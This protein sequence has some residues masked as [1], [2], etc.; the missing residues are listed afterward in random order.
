VCVVIV[1]LLTDCLSVAHLVIHET[2]S[3]TRYE[4]IQPL[5]METT[6]SMLSTV[7]MVVQRCDGPHRLRDNDDDDDVNRL[8]FF[9]HYIYWTVLCSASLAHWHFS[10]ICQYCRDSIP[11]HAITESHGRKH[12]V[13][14]RFTKKTKYL[15]TIATGM[16]NMWPERL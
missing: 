6:G 15:L 9:Q 8:H 4:M 11:C 12:S 16:P 2:S 1:C 10:R 14:K 13:K 7:D 3:L 5:P